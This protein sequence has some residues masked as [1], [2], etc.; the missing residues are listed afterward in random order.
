MS[1]KNTKTKAASIF[2]VSNILYA[3]VILLALAAAIVLIVMGRAKP[4][5]IPDENGAEDYS[6]AVL[7]DNEICEEAPK[8][9]CRV[10]GVGIDENADSANNSAK[11]VAEA[12]SSFSGVAVLQ[13]TECETEKV[14]FTV[15]CERTAGNLRVMLMSENMYVL[16]DFAV[17]ESSSFTVENAKGKT[18][19]LRAAGESAEFTIVVERAFE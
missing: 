4:I 2:T 6:L 9:S 3:C 13:K 1:K 12:K 10:F 5:D 19:Q 7:T 16:H 14:T 18:F 17:G 8:Y 11:I 15:N